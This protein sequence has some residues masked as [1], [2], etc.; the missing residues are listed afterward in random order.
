MISPLKFDSTRN[1]WCTLWELEHFSELTREFKASLSRVQVILIS[2]ISISVQAMRNDQMIVS[3]IN[4]NKGEVVLYQKA[5]MVAIGNTN[6]ST[7]N[8]QSD[9]AKLKLLVNLSESHQSS[10]K[11][12]GKPKS[13][14][15]YLRRKRTLLQLS[16]VKVNRPTVTQILE[17][18]LGLVCWYGGSTP[19][20]GSWS[21]LVITDFRCFP[22]DSWTMI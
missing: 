10:C 11:S 2:I 14:S 12:L 13:T 20:R 16:F 18:R 3:N 15:Q 17:K 9:A 8:K 4:N 22:M 1:G 5:M 7:L 21:H 6:N 19:T